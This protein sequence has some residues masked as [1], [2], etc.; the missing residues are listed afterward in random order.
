[1]A[2]RKI[3]LHGRIT[4]APTS[5]VQKYIVTIIGEIATARSSK[6]AK[7]TIYNAVRVAAKEIPGAQEFW[8][9][10]PRGQRSATSPVISRSSR[11]EV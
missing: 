9:S 8:V 7:L 5:T 11:P 3:A 6:D 1:M 10:Q 2:N 4:G